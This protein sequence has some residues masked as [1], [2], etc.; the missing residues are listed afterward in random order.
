MDL[1]KKKKKRFLI[2][3]GLLGVILLAI[4]IV[5]AYRKNSNKK[6]EKSAELQQ[7]ET[8][9]NEKFK[10]EVGVSWADET[11][12]CPYL[13]ENDPVMAELIA[14]ERKII[15]E[16]N[17]DYKDKE[18]EKLRRIPRNYVIELWKKGYHWWDII[19]LWDW[20]IPE[21]EVPNLKAKKRIGVINE[22]F[23]MFDFEKFKDES[24]SE[25][26]WRKNPYIGGT[27]NLVIIVQKIVTGGPIIN[28][29]Q[30][31][32]N[33]PTSEKKQLGHYIKKL[34]LFTLNREN[35]DP[36]QYKVS[37]L[38]CAG[39]ENYGREKKIAYN[40]SAGK[41]ATS[42]TFL[43]LLSALYQKPIAKEVA[44]TGALTLT[45]Y[46]KKGKINGKEIQLVVET[47]L[48]IKGLKEKVAACVEK[49]INRLVLSKY[50]SSPNLLSVFLPKKKTDSWHSDGSPV[51]TE[52]KWDL[53][54]D[55]QQVVPPENQKK[56]KVYFAKNTKE[57]K[58]LLDEL[59]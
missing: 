49:G 45:K 44:A 3:T 1:P 14:R 46:F 50:Q 21:K 37:F 38:S 24:I 27:K 41:S 6:V 48:P 31:L 58:N 35:L 42:A 12:N 5:F 26:E 56:M 53:A 29:S 28:I 51:Y 57:L 40:R 9:I 8:K 39:A 32:F 33:A 13:D 52:E 16:R 36:R 30:G 34:I 19:E 25:E 17:K 11:D 54:E 15:K 43:A 59:L 20:Q 18:L 22:L 55:Y 7:Q 10:D 2:L 4:I 47:N 23:V